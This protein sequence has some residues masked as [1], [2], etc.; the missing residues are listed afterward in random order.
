MI[1]WTFLNYWGHPPGLPTKSMPM[2]QPTYYNT[3]HNSRFHQ[4]AIYHMAPKLALSHR[5]VSWGVWCRD[6]AD[7]TNMQSITWHLNWP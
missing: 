5:H 7:S 1:A 3:S 6:S 4:Y 2:M